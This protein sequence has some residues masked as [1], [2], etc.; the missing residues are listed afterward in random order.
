MEGKADLETGLELYGWMDY[1]K[2][3]KPKVE[4]F[5]QGE[6]ILDGS[7]MDFHVPKNSSLISNGK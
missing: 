4:N 7:Q 1:G 3:Q 6:G 5:R 2:I